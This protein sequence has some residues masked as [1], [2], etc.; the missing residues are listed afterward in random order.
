M[1]ERLLAYRLRRLLIGSRQDAEWPSVWRVLHRATPARFDVN[2]M[3]LFRAQ[4]FLALNPRLWL[5]LSVNQPPNWSSGWSP[6]SRALR[7]TEARGGLV[8]SGAGALQ[9]FSPAAARLRLA[10]AARVPLSRSGAETA[11]AQAEPHVPAAVAAVLAPRSLPRLSVAERWSLPPRTAAD[12]PAGY[13][14]DHPGMSARYAPADFSAPA[15]VLGRPVPV[16]P[17]QVQPA[18]VAPAATLSPR[19][20]T[21]TAAA[22][23]PPMLSPTVDQLTD[24]VLRTLDQRLLAERE[25]LSRR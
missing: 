11:H 20:W 3:H 22:S 24:N 21:G 23:S 14:S 4:L 17:P 18:T 15:R 5:R 19:Y 1:R 9:A 7:A 13:P 2:Q 16:L 25:R 8:R 10:S 12:A 6:S